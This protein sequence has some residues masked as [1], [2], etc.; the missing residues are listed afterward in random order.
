MGSVF[1]DDGATDYTGRICDEYAQNDVRFRVVHTRNQ[2]LA[3]VRNTGMMVEFGL[4]LYFMD[5][6]DWIE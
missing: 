1:V 4:L 3:C 5:P 2:G 6:D